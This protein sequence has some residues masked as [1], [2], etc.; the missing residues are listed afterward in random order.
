MEFHTPFILTV[1][2]DPSVYDNRQGMGMRNS[3]IHQGQAQGDDQIG[4]T[5]RMENIY[6]NNPGEE[7]GDNP[8]DDPHAISRSKMG[9]SQAGIYDNPSQIGEMFE[10]EHLCISTWYG[11]RSKG[12][13]CL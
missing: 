5:S 2:A 3:S 10:N 6:S 7:R 12:L 11:Y 4:I 1:G 13:F 8:Y 9:Y